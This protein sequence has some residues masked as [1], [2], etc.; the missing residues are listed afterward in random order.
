MAGRCIS[1]NTTCYRGSLQE[2]S[3]LTGNNFCSFF[4]E[5]KSTKTPSNSLQQFLCAGVPVL[6]Q[7]NMAYPTDPPVTKHDLV[8]IRS[9]VKSVDGDALA[10]D[11]RFTSTSEL[12]DSFQRGADPQSLRLL[13]PVY[14]YA[15][16]PQPP[17]PPLSRVLI[18]TGVADTSLRYVYE[19]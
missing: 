16:A 7:L 11:C 3:K 17:E 12:F 19:Y 2:Y 6:F 10:T 15:D 13:S 8:G 4:V 18:M 5:A 14:S 1:I 9:L